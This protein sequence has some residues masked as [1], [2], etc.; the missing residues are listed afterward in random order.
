MRGTLPWH[1]TREQAPPRCCGGIPQQGS[2][3]LAALRRLLNL[4]MISEALSLA[5]MHKKICGPCMSPD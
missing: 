3:L 4:T 1:P 2:T 5:L